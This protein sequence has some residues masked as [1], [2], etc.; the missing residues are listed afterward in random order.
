MV[1]MQDAHQVAPRARGDRVDRG[2]HLVERVGRV[3]AHV[4]SPAHL[5]GERHRHA[6]APQ[7]HGEAGARLA[8]ELRCDATVVPLAAEVRWR[9]DVSP[10]P[11]DPLFQVGASIDAITPGARQHLMR[12]LHANHA[13]R[14]EAHG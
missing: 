9:R 3:R 14:R 13:L 8:V 11:A 4:A 7:L 10:H 6:V 12:F 2:A 5:G 1:G